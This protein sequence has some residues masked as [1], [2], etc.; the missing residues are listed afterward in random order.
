MLWPPAIVPDGKNPDPPFLKKNEALVAS[1][2]SKNIAVP[3]GIES[4]TAR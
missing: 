4:K 2:L 3:F 1:A